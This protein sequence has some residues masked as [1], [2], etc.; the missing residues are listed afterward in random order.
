MSQENVVVVLYITWGAGVNSC[1]FVVG[2]VLAKTETAVSSRLLPSHS[3]G[4]A[5]E[6]IKSAVR[7]SAEA[8]AGQGEAT[9]LSVTGIGSLCAYRV[10]W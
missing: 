4:N 6:T 1:P 5:A 7:R 3:P 9:A 2:S 8:A 10:C